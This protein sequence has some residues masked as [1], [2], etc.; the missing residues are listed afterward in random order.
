MQKLNLMLNSLKKK[1]GIKNDFSRKVFL[2][3]KVFDI[4]G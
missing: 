1:E 3:Q 4:I 2:C